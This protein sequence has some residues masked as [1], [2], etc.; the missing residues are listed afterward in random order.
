ML[1]VGLAVLGAV[2]GQFAIELGAG[3]VPVPAGYNWLIP[4][5]NAGLVVLV[6]HLPSPASRTSMGP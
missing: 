3:R 4:I 5:A 6:A 1:M 2:L